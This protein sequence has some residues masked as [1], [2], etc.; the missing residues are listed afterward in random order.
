M[1]IPL[2]KS[3]FSLKGRSILTLDK[4]E[5]IKD[6]YPVSI[7]AIA[8]KHKLKEIYLVEDDMGGFFEAYKLFV[9]NG[10]DLKFG[11]NFIVTHI[12]A[13]KDQSVDNESKVTVFIKNNKG[14]EDLCRLHNLYQTD[15]NSFY[16][17]P[18]IDW[19]VFNENLTDNLQVVIPPYDS[20]IERN[21]FYNGQITPKLPDNT[22]VTYCDNMGLVWEKELV[23]KIKNYNPNAI[24][25]HPIYYY[26]NEDFAAWQVF[27]CIDA[28]TT[29]E[30]PE[31][32][33]SR[34]VT[35]KQIGRA[36]V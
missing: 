26:K 35:G 28:G 34:I 31:L 17:Y 30:K 33:R 12:T 3:H 1:I 5:D 29:V 8:K 19:K 20:F 13:E 9:K 10:I 16:Y 2:F 14:Y 21:T 23:A 27:K 15:K 7:Y 24:E 11:L 6:D 32:E 25:V 18:R 22:I 36:H 4:D